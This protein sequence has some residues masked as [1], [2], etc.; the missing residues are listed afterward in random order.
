MGATGT[1]GWNFKVEELDDNKVAYKVKVEPETT[2]EDN[3]GYIWMD[4]DNFI[5]SS[6]FE[7]QC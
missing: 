4:N 7:F 6:K 5:T 3:H 2:R 1:D